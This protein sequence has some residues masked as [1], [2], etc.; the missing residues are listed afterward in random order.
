MFIY[1][2]HISLKD[3]MN[4]CKLFEGKD[5]LPLVIL[6]SGKKK[7]P[8]WK[9]KL[10]IQQNVIYFAENTRKILLKQI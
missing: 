7:L 1:T 2:N 9:V 6:Q 3:A 5:L 4:E 10:C 8:K